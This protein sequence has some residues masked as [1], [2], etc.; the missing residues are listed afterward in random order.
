MSHSSDLSKNTNINIRSKYVLH[1]NRHEP[2]FHQL[3]P[4]HAPPVF[5]KVTIPKIRRSHRVGGEGAET[6]DESDVE[7]SSHSQRSIYRNY[8]QQIDDAIDDKYLAYTIQK[9]RDANA[10]T[11]GARENL[12]EDGALALACCTAAYN[13]GDADDNEYIII[14]KNKYPHLQQLNGEQRQTLAEVKH[15]AAVEA[16]LARGST[17]ATYHNSPEYVD[18]VDSRVRRHV[19]E[20]EQQTAELL[21]ATRVNTQ[22]ESEERDVKQK[23]IR[24]RIFLKSNSPFSAAQSVVV[25]RLEE[26]LYATSPIDLLV[27]KNRT[28]CQYSNLPVV[29]RLNELAIAE[30]RAKESESNFTDSSCALAEARRRRKESQSR[31]AMGDISKDLQRAIRGKSAHAIGSMLYA[32]SMKK[33]KSSRDV[34]EASEECVAKCRSSMKG[35][36]ALMR[37]SQGYEVCSEEEAQQ[38]MT[39]SG[40][41]TT[42]RT[43]HMEAMDE[44]A[45]DNMNHNVI[46]SL[47][48]CRY[49]LKNLSHTSSDMYAASR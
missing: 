47:E 40:G 38:C 13:D 15:K 49:Q 48:A 6:G 11:G 34:Q 27:Q 29:R 46:N 45:I 5:P 30:E 21:A 25:S 24:H 44:R 2:L 23:R 7:S 31:A 33:I 22:R 1:Q 37:Q 12:I 43:I 18:F 10:P 28:R 9:Q 32:E 19:R 41:R 36:R 26:K 39:Y 14:R 3:L 42:H 16:A 35:S 20:A 17:R 4:Y 8:P